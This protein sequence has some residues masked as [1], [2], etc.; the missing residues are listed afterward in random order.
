MTDIKTIFG[1]LAV[2]LTL[3]GY[4]PYFRD[5][6][7]RTTRPHIFSWFIWGIT[8]GIVYALQVSAGGG[9]G[10][11]VTL[12]LVLI[13]VAVFF[14]SFKHGTKDITKTDIIFL[15]LALSALPLWLIVKQPVLSIILLATIDILGF[16]PT[17]RKSWNDPYSETLSFYVITTFR[18]GITVLALSQYNIITILYP[19]TWILANA[20]FSL[21]LIARRKKIKPAQK[22]R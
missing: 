16:I 2:I 12:V 8:T 9:P 21:I 3:I 4:V 20:T 6:F 13:F 19:L 15:I 17:I 14:L 11:W 5:I 7:K 10:T 22:F 1:A 18:H